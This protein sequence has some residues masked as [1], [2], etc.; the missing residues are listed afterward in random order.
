MNCEAPSTKQL[1]CCLLQMQFI[2]QYRQSSRAGRR[3]SHADEVKMQ[4]VIMELT[5]LHRAHPVVV[6]PPA[7]LVDWN[8]FPVVQILRCCRASGF[9]QGVQ[10]K[11]LRFRRLL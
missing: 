6:A 2:L 4:P 3:R 8:Y 5:S 1:I 11:R 10:V 7:C 9:H